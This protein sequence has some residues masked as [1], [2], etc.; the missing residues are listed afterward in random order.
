MVMPFESEEGE[1]K[2]QGSYSSIIWAE[3]EDFSTTEN[4]PCILI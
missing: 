2:K 3:M 4:E 1:P